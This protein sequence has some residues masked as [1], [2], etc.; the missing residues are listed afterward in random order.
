M[1]SNTNF[2]DQKVKI[3]DSDQFSRVPPSKSPQNADISLL[4]KSRDFLHRSPG[5]NYAQKL[6]YTPRGSLSMLN[7]SRTERFCHNNISDTSNWTHLGAKTVTQIG[8]TGVM[9]QREGSGYSIYSRKTLGRFGVEKE[10]GISECNQ[11]IEK[12]VGE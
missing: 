12:L 11:H 5:G 7:G 2:E 1:T 4:V 3:K 9:G 8:G 6:K 10:M